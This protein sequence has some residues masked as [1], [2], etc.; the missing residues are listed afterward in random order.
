M[1]HCNHLKALQILPKI[2]NMLAGEEHAL[3]AAAASPKAIP[4][5]PVGT[6]ALASSMPSVEDAL[7]A[8]LQQQEA[9]DDAAAERPGRAQQDDADACQADRPAGLHCMLHS[10]ASAGKLPGH[11]P[12]PLTLPQAVAEALTAAAYRQGSPDNLAVVAV[13][14]GGGMHGRADPAHA[15]ESA[16]E[17]GMENSSQRA[18]GSAAPAAQQPLLSVPRRGTAP[19]AFLQGA[20][21]QYQLTELLTTLLRPPA[22]QGA[23][24]PALPSS[25]APAL[26]PEGGGSS[27]AQAACVWD[28]HTPG[29]QGGSRD[30]DEVCWNPHAEQLQL[31]P[32]A[33]QI[34]Q[35]LASVPLLQPEQAP[36]AGAALSDWGG[37]V[38][39][40]AQSLYHS[41][42]GLLE[43]GRPGSKIGGGRYS[44]DAQ[45]AQ[46]AFGEVWRAERRPAAGGESFIRLPAC[47][48]MQEKPYAAGRPRLLAALWPA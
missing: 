31:G 37:S 45:F 10:E 43:R 12:R 1:H 40:V 24:V 7:E 29:Q 47:S 14:L 15:E 6:L 30:G 39:A 11:R 41:W 5:P 46:G 33:S 28:P 9:V 2:Q 21:D 13:V 4:L 42:A 48:T 23:S 8:A 25:G 22:P 32:S 3:T 16:G 35:L 17:Q 36:L 38:S 34:V 18:A 26:P 27:L 19:G 44:L 20:R